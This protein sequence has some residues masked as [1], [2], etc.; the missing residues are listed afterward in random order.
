M[1]KPDELPIDR[2]NRKNKI[3]GM[4][5]LVLI[6]AGGLLWFSKNEFDEVFDSIKKIRIDAALKAEGDRQNKAIFHHAD[7]RGKSNDE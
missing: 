4:V 7:F 6:V 3:I 2:A 5:T 1:A